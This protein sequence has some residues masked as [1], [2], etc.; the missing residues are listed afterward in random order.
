[1]RIWLIIICVLWFPASA[2]ALTPAMIGAVS[3][4][5]CP[6]HGTDWSTWTGANNGTLVEDYLGTQQWNTG[7]YESLG[8][9]TALHVYATTDDGGTTYRLESAIVTMEPNC[10]TLSRG[11]PNILTT[12]NAIFSLPVTAKLSS[13]RF[14]SI[15]SISNINDLEVYLLDETG[16]VIDS[17]ILVDVVGNGGGLFELAAHSSTIAVAAYR[18]LSDSDLGAVAIDVTGDNI[19][20]GSEVELKDAITVRGPGIVA[21]NSTRGL[22]TDGNGAIRY[23][24]SGTTITAGSEIAVDSLAAA[25]VGTGVYRA[26]MI[27]TNTALVTYKPG[28]G[29][30]SGKL[31]ASVLKDDGT[32]LSRLSQDYMTSAYGTV[33]LRSRHSAEVQAYSSG[34]TDGLY[35]LSFEDT[36]NDCGLNMMKWNGTAIT[37]ITETT[38]ATSPIACEHGTLFAY[39]NGLLVAHWQDDV[40]WDWKVISP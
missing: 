29:G 33:A 11:T 37:L 13:T 23:T 34:I 31:K 22:V 19:V 6:S 3:H 38:L 25:W 40:Y 9:N 27:D 30:A 32:T 17:D 7:T 10:K 35:L 12:W 5:G 1:M 16:A 39:N 2:W 14:L 26:M 21:M 20:F 18:R 8:D 28:Y 24:L 4:A 36:N 15:A